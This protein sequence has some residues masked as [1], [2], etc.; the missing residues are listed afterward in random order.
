MNSMNILK[1][2][3]DID[4][5]YLMEDFET[6]NEKKIKINGIKLKYILAPVCTVVIAVGGMILYND[7]S[8]NGV[9]PVKESQNI[10]D[11]E[12]PK[13]ES[14]ATTIN[15]NKIDNMVKADL[16][17]QEKVLNGINIPYFEYMKG[18]EIPSDFDNKENYKAIYVRSNKET[19]NYDVLNNYE[20]TYKNTFNK[21]KIILAFSEKFIPIR[22]CYEILGDKKVSKIG[23]AELVISQF[24]NIYIVK[25]THKNI[26][27]DI[28]TTDITESELISL[29]ESIINRINN[30]IK[31]KG[32]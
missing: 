11:L 25:F 15:I 17:A 6:T 32:T 30:T 24:Q 9:I 2:I 10:V 21:R 14:F 5:K 31:V 4:D 29:L 19:N 28:E 22:E 23:E 7:K 26:N 3:G 20:F 8:N 12:N 16:D 27:F 18:L 1:A 13:E